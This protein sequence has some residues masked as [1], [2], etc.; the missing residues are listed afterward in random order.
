MSNK[1]YDVLKY[2]AQIGLP[3][4]GTLYYDSTDRTAGGGNSV[5][6]VI[7]N[8][9]ITIRRTDSWNNYSSRY[10]SGNAVNDKFFCIQQKGE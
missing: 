6:C 3:A 7:C 10:V 9:G 4:V 5:L 1:L 2:I 8:L